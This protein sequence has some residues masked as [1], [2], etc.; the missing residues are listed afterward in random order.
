MPLHYVWEGVAKVK[1]TRESGD[2]PKVHSN[3]VAEGN[4]GLW[5]S[6]GPTFKRI[7]YAG[8]RYGAPM[9][10]FRISTA[11]PLLSLVFSLS[12][13]AEDSEPYELKPDMVVTPSRVAESLSETLASVSVIT[14]EDIESSVAEDLFELLRLQPGV[15]IVRNGGPG[16]QTS[17]FLRGSNSNHVLVL[18]D[19]VRV[20]SSNTGAYAWEQLP[21]NQV[22]R[23]EIVRGPRGSTYGSDSIGGVIQVFTR[24]SPDPYARITAGSYGTSE[25]EGGFGFEGERTK[26]S[27][28]AGYRHVDGF[29]AQN[30]DGFSYHPDDDG[31]KGAS[32]GIKGSSQVESGRW[33]YSILALD[34]ESDFDQGTS[35]A[36]QVVTS[37]GFNGSFS[38]NWDY[39][40]IGGYVNDE[41]FSDF[42]FFTSDF[43]SRRFDFSWQ[44]QLTAGRDGGFGFG[45]DYYREKGKSLYSWDESRNNTGLFASFDQYFSKLHLQLSGRFDD[46]SRFGSEF[47]G[48][49]A[50]GYDFGDAWQLMGSYGSAFRGPNLSEQFSPGFGGLFAGN[51]DLNPESSTSGELGLRWR[52]GVAGTLS[53]ALYRTDV[54]DLISFS[55]EDFQ[56]INIEEA[57]LEGLELEYQLVHSGWHLDANA[58]FQNTENRATSE[59]LLRRPDEKGSVT[60]DRRF[61][62]GSWLGVEWF[63]SGKRQDVGDITLA[64]YNLVNLRA[65]WVF[66][67]AWRLELRADNLLD[68]DYEP[69]FGFNSPGRSAYLSLAWLP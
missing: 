22:E 25:F 60:I 21:I 4:L 36:R 51:P 26:L 54:V 9:Y 24:S 32:L 1:I 15:D 6:P 16:A 8:V 55:G 46:N 39:Q 48:Q 61:D 64:G 45:L 67:P 17:V 52:G 68:E 33:Q 28:N 10:P 2:R 37:A 7:T 69:A 47:T 65:G 3:S 50:L 27:I 62:N 40:L 42:G 66:T 12:I 58:T 19:G 34:S 41:L 13:Q 49:L 14:R 23:I 31:F 53:M 30:P 57:L 59:S 35:E 11:M 20:S 63:V 29:S 5:S 44:N 43:E 18:I 38:P 56:A